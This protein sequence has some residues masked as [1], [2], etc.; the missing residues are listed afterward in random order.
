VATYAASKAAAWSYTNAARLQLKLQGTEVVSVHVGAVDTDMQ[1]GNEVEKIPPAAVA[2]RA[3][4]A[5]VEA[6][7]A[8]EAAH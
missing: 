1:A 5:L 6:Q 4:D 2:T 7:F 8:A 3:L